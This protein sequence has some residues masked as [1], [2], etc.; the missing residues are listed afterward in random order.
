MWIWCRINLVN[1]CC[2]EEGTGNRSL[3]MAASAAFGF[4]LPRRGYTRGPSSWLLPLQQRDTSCESMLPIWHRI[5]ARAKA[6]LRS[7]GFDQSIS[8]AM[9]LHQY[10]KLCKLARE[11]DWWSAGE[12][13]GTLKLPS[14]GEKKKK[15]KAGQSHTTKFSN[16]VLCMQL[17]PDPSNTSLFLNLWLKATARAYIEK[18]HIPL[19]TELC[20]C[21][22]KSQLMLDCFVCLDSSKFS[23]WPGHKI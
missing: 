17:W 23:A 1:T 2:N 3:F 16:G 5:T 9:S 18:L 6:Q 19:S 15:K 4:S 13:C 11:G 12:Q 7:A 20:Q 8:W 14:G 21:N 10:M 22:Y